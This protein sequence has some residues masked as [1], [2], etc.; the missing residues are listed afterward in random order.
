MQLDKFL[1]FSRVQ[2]KRKLIEWLVLNRGIGKDIAGTE[3]NV[4]E[5]IY[6]RSTDF[7]DSSALRAYRNKR[8]KEIKFMLVH[9]GDNS[10]E[11]VRAGYG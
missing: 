9:V 10:K 2:H 3:E 5:R 7:I 6:Y 4:R 8:T 11:H 1:D